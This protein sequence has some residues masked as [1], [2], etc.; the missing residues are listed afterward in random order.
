MSMLL[1]AQVPVML[2]VG[3]ACRLCGVWKQAHCCGCD[4]RGS[5]QCSLVL[6]ISQPT[7]T[8]RTITAQ[9]L[10]K[11]MCSLL[12]Q[13]LW[14]LIPKTCLPSPPMIKT[15]GLVG[16][17]GPA[18]ESP[19]LVCGYLARTQF[20]AYGRRAVVRCGTKECIAVWSYSISSMSS[21][22]ASQSDRLEIEWAETV[23]TGTEAMILSALGHES[24][25]VPGRQP[26]GLNA[27]LMRSRQV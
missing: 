11:Q 22:G 1:R 6:K 24:E 23:E 4:V 26:A 19:I 10:L 14:L 18:A 27:R 20:V 21:R 17:A 15:A 25:Q 3:V 16:F 9:V 2:I 8:L 7:N 5:V 12:Q 13:S